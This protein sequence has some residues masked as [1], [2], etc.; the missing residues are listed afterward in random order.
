MRGHTNKVWGIHNLN[1]VEI[2]QN[3]R[4][5]IIAKMSD[6]LKHIKC[7]YDITGTSYDLDRFIIP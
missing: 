7:Y 4:Y 6:L 3:I 5:K 2:D 1:Y